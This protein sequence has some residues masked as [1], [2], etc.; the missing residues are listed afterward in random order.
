MGSQASATA[1]VRAHV[2]A[3]TVHTRELTGLTG[4]HRE[5]VNVCLWHRDVDAEVRRFVETALLARAVRVQ[6]TVTVGRGQ[7][8]AA[9][10]PTG[11]DGPGRDAWLKDVRLL[12]DVYGDLLGFSAVG[13]RVTTLPRPMCPRFHVDRVGVRLVCT[14]AGTG[15]QWLDSGDVDRS[16]LGPAAGSVPDEASGLVLAPERV[17]TMPAFAVGLFKGEGWPGN[18]GNGAVHRSPPMQPG[19]M[20]LVLTLDGLS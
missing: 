13:L 6:S 18:H 1:G 4:I 9:L 7:E 5:G 11:C 19:E 20:R 2:P 10:L 15:T 16:K 17:H 14:Y 12:V 3:F 8:I